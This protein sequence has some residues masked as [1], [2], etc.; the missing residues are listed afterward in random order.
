MAGLGVA[1]HTPSSLVVLSIAEHTPSG[2][3]KD[4]HDPHNAA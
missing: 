4:P 1:E 2:L 3:V